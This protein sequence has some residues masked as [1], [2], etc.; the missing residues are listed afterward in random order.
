MGN[1]FPASR[2][3]CCICKF[4]QCDGFDHRNLFNSIKSL[5]C[6]MLQSHQSDELTI[7]DVAISPRCNCTMSQFTIGLTESHQHSSNDNVL[8]GP[9][10]LRCC[11][12]SRDPRTTSLSLVKF[13]SQPHSS[14]CQHLWHLQKFHVHAH[15]D[16]S[17]NHGSLLWA[18]PEQDD[19]RVGDNKR[20]PP[21]LNLCMK[22]ARMR[23]CCFLDIV[24]AS[25]L[26]FKTE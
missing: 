21:N 14:S 24:D 2:G 17:R 20:Q 22:E 11:H 8:S 13:T 15:C 6:T 19:F 23:C 1:L 16:P 4:A 10:T 5:K 25:N 9:T 26:C 3:T 18:Q 12:T 7:V